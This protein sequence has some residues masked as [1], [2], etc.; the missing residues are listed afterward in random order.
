MHPV[1]A[2]LEGRQTG[3]L[4]FAVLQI[5]QVLAG[6]LAD[7]LQVVQLAVVPFAD[8]PAIADHRRG[9]VD[10]G[11]LQQVGQLRIGGDGLAQAAYMLAG[12]G[13]DA[14]LQF[15]QCGQGIAQSRQ[16]PRARR[17]QGDP[18]ENPLDI[19]DALEHRVQV[20]VVV[21]LDQP[22]D[23]VLAC[24]QGLHLA[25]RTIEPARQQAAAHGGG[26][27]VEYIQQGIVPAA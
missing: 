23:A 13:L 18:R 26:G 16:I 12:D 19:A 17:A 15:G 14:A 24:A 27:M 8:H 2:D 22:G 10:D 6:V 20:L 11:P 3:A 21:V 7:V 9:I 1:V 25:Q 5:D 4:A